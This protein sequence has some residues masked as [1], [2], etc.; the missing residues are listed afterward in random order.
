MKK[1]KLVVCDDELVQRKF[2][3]VLLERF[4]KERK[5]P[6]EITMAPERNFWKIKSR[7]LI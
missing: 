5:I 2:L 1:I 6:V 4:F 3:G 7:I